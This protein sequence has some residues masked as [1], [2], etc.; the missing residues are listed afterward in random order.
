VTV[1]RRLLYVVLALVGL[2]LA[3]GF[4]LPKSA[5]VERAITTA[6]S[7]DA[8]YGIVSGFRR[9]NEWSPWSDLD[10]NA[11]YT[12]SGPE[13]GAG[14]KMTWAS[15][16]PDVGSGSQEIVSVEPGHV[17]RTRLEFGGQGPSTST[18]TITPDGG[19]SRIVWAFDTS[20][21]GNYFG[22]YMGLM[23][24]KFIGKDYEKGLA[25]LKTIAEAAPSAQ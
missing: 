4:F 21:E 10:P 14:A 17:V 5:H 3:A 2:V 23:F 6:A 7:P 11:R 13:S 1:V 15:D 9:F 24:D 19:G 22:R 12:Y 25:K 18:L 20:F 8:V 16:K